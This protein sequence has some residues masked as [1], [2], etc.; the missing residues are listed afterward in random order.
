MIYCYY[1]HTPSRKTPPVTNDTLSIAERAVIK[2]AFNSSGYVLNFSN[3]TFDSFTMESAGTSIQGY[4]QASKGRSF[5]MFI[6][7]LEVPTANKIK[8]VTDLLDY[9]E[10]INLATTSYC[11]ADSTI[12]KL[13]EIVK[14][15]E[16]C[17]RDGITK[18]QAD[19]IKHAFNS[20]YADNQI[21]QML[22]SINK[23][24]SDAI[25]KAKELIESCCKTILR[26]RGYVD[27]DSFDISALIKL[28]KNELEL[29]SEYPAIKK[30]IGGLSGITTGI[31]ELRNAKGTGHGR[32]VVQFKEPSPIE[33]KL[34][35][36][37]AI[38]MVHFFWTLHR[39]KMQ[40]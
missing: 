5:E 32:D 9:Y 26:E 28:V 13:K 14:R 17:V 27:L 19:S 3:N 22:R 16:N 4:Y 21:N 36:D 35:V 10:G 39:S 1:K 8:L 12:T 40:P 11:I 31:T 29:K 30:I 34:A 18:Q 6:D 2:A 38:A 20:E 15:Y 24:P 23:H 37:S 7:D 33:A 25:G